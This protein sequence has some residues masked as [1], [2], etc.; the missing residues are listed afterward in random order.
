MRLRTRTAVWLLVCAGLAA[1]IGVR[2]T[3]SDPFS[4]KQRALWSI[5][6]V[7]PGAPP[8]VTN[9]AWARTPIDAFVLA[10]LEKAG[11]APA[12]PADRITLIRRASLDLIGLPPTP[13]EVAAFVAD[14]SPNAFDKVIDRL[15]AS[16]QR[17][18][19]HTSELQS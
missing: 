14:K 8:G 2:A 11:I 10:D 15:L 9:K 7:R 19:E 1:A 18:E 13:A 17:S 6:P 5:Q 12:A 4:A 16:P 3:A